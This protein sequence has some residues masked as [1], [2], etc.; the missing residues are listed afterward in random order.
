MGKVL[1]LHGS[2]SLAFNFN[3]L[4]LFFVPLKQD[5]IIQRVVLDAFADCTVLTIA[6]SQLLTFFIAQ[7]HDNNNTLSSLL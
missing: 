5:K 2:C 1:Q 3:S 4:I 7:T 6:V